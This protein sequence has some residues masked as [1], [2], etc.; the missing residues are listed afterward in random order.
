MSGYPLDPDFQYS[1]QEFLLFAI[2][3]GGLKTEDKFV[4]EIFKPTII[5]CH[6][7]T[8]IA[9]NSYHSFLKN[10]SRIHFFLKKLSDYLLAESPGDVVLLHLKSGSA[11]FT[12]YNKSFCSKTEKCARDDIQEVCTKLRRPGEDV[13]PDFAEAMLPEFTIEQIGEVGYAGICLSTTKPTNE[14]VVFNRTLTGFKGG[15]CW[16]TN[17]LLA[18]LIVV[19]STT[20]AFLIVVH[21]QKYHKKTFQPQC[22]PSCGHIN[23]KMDTP[24]SRKSPLLEEDVPPSTRLPVSMVSQQRSFRANQGLVIS[25][26]P[27]PPKYRLPPLYGRRDPG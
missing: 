16:I 10:R 1:P 23:F 3:S 2:D 27:P 12:W 4:V 8:V 7:Y 17:A 5:P 6:V 19:C 22:P 18:L 24:T 14:S 11:V 21:C 9:T 15:S 26:L 20:L 13:H 25:R